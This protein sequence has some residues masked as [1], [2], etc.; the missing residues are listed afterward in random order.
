MAPEII[1]GGDDVMG[2]L[3]DAEFVIADLG[4]EDAWLSVEEGDA[5]IVADWA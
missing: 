5:P 4:R 1:Q 2:S 3:D